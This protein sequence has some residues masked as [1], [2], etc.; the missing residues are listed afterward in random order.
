MQVSKDRSSFFSVLGK[1]VNT[2]TSM[3]QITIW[4]AGWGI[5]RLRFFRVVAVFRGFIWNT[6]LVCRRRA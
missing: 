4:R 3:N 6:G 5:E 2:N 1:K